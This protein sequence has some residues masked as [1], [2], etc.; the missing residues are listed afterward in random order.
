LN[1]LSQKI[2]TVEAEQMV[3][4]SIAQRTMKDHFPLQRGVD[5]AYMPAVRAMPSVF[6]P[7]VVSTGLVVTS[8]LCGFFFG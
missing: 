3:F 6:L 7:S 4:R 8:A 5:E 2:S 1:F